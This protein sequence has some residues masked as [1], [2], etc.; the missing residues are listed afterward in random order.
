LNLDSVVVAYGKLQKFV[1]K[2]SL[3]EA[4]LDHTR[5]VKM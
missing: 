2:S 4:R 3:N 5:L 1:P